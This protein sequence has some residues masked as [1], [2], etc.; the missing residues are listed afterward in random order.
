MSLFGSL[1]P[2]IGTVGGAVIGGPVGA[3]AG[4]ALGGA[5]AGNEKYQ[6]QREVE[7]KT[8]KLA[9]ETARY[10]PWTHMTPGAIQYAGSDTDAIGGGALA[11]G[12]TG[13]S[14]G[15]MAA[16]VPKPGAGPMGPMPA[17]GSSA[18]PAA[19][20][21]GLGVNTQLPQTQTY[22]GGSPWPNMFANNNPYASR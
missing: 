9:A 1:A 3:A 22:G 4:G 15:T 17:L 16:G 6:R 7:D 5:I 12:M 21:Y 11:G 10:S 14:L 19:P 13:Y 2:I 18:V 20:S 8:R